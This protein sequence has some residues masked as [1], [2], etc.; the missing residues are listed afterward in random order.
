MTTRKPIRRSLKRSRPGLMRLEQRLMFDGAAVETGLDVAAQADTETS[1]LVDAAALAVA[2]AQ[3]QARQE[4]V[5]VDAA[6]DGYQAIIDSLVDGT[7]I[8]VLDPT[9]DGVAQI[10]DFLDGRSGI[11]AVH[12]VGHGAEGVQHL[13]GAVLSSDTL[14]QYRASF[15]RIGLALDAG[16]DILL[17]GCRVGSGEGQ[18]FVDSLATLAHADIAASDDLSGNPASGGDWQLE[19]RVGEIEADTL[20]AHVAGFDGVLAPTV[21]DPGALTTNEDTAVA[22]SGVDVTAPDNSFMEVVA[23]VTAGD[24]TLRSLSVESDVLGS[25]ADL[26][27]IN[28]FLDTLE[29]VPDPGWSGTAT[30]EIV[31][32]SDYTSRGD[33]TTLSIDV[34]VQAVNDAP[35][36]SSAIITIDEDATYTFSAA[37]FGYADAGDS[38][39]DSLLEVIVDTAPLSGEL[40]LDGALIGDG[41]VIAAGDLPTLTYTPATNAN[42]SA[43]ASLTFRVRD[44]GG[45]DNSGANTSAQATLTFDVSALNDAPLADDLSLSVDKNDS[46]TFSLN[47]SDVDGGA[48]AVNDAGLVGFTVISVPGNGV[49]RDGEGSVLSDGAEV[50][51]A[52]ATDMTFTPTTNYSGEVS[53]DYVG[54]DEAGLTSIANATVTITVAAVNAAPSVTVPVDGQT[55]DEDQSVAISGISI[56]DIDA[57]SNLIEVTLEAGQGTLALA[58]VNSLFSDPAGTTPL[59]A[60]PASTLLFYGTLSAINTALA[61]VTYAGAE[62]YFGDDTLTVTVDD[63]GYSAGAGAGT[64]QTDSDIVSITVGPVADAPTTPDLTLPTVA[65]DQAEINGASIA[66]LMASAGFA[67]VDTDA[68]AGVAISANPDNS[69]AGEWQFSLTNGASWTAV[70]SVDPNN[71]L[72]L[73]ASAFIRFLPAQDYNGTPPALTVHAIDDSGSRTYTSVASSPL[74]LDVTGQC[75]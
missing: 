9:A 40:R 56:S 3:T 54:R 49:L 58:S 15:T 62:N 57:G 39:A 21:V 36:G 13:G 53:F 51:L 27:G 28:S 61:T 66:S 19:Y 4:I 26:A 6:I 7:E 41:E 37:S 34:T 50:S 14:E 2:P 29:F 20:F 18:V 1:A 31:V 73:S 44:D 16:A 42:G 8:V 55:V 60:T 32:E 52:Q 23:T 45:T 75:H 74:T 64:P 25:Q 46:L 47:G 17:Y 59:G 30:V 10:A 38:P 12:L 35:S 24:G 71:A 65:E 68:I 33:T 70:G 67:D 69:G 11:D 43:Y 5:F 63:L 72:L 48:N 22:L